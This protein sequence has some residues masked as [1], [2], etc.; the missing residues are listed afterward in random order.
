MAQAFGANNSRA[1][2]SG[3]WSGQVVGICVATAGIALIVFFRDD[4]I[5]RL[6]EDAVIA[7]KAGSYLLVTTVLFLGLAASQNISVFLYATDNP[8]IPFYS[9]LLELPV[10]ALLSY[11]LIYGVWGMPELG[12]VGA[13]IGSAVA[14]LLRCVYLTCYLYSKNFS[15]LISPG[16]FNGSIKSAV[17]THLNNALPIAG[18]FVSMNFAYTVCMMVYSQLEII[19]FAAF[20]VLFIWLRVSGML[21]T[22]W[23]QSVGIWVGR[24]I[25][26]ESMGVLGR[27]V[28]RAWK[29]AAG[30]SLMIAAIYA[31]TPALFDILYPSLDEQTIDVI[32]ILVPLLVLLPLVRTSNTI[33]GNVLRASGQA[34]YAFLVHI[35]AQWL[36]TVPMTVLF[37]LVLEISAFWVFAIILFEEILKSVPFHLRI[38][39][40]SWKH[41]SQA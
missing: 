22:S 35:S 14:V 7:N 24:L 11:S 18:T 12:V 21:A 3:F 27:F 8:K 6:T 34:T 30:I 16:W 10:N 28:F 36:F 38:L 9:N 5:S 33:C 4:I 25:G 31:V 32:R 17:F 39:S 26:Q 20:T 13:A 1:L 2:K 40:G 19:E 41:Y 37:V 15:Y 23:S 29:I